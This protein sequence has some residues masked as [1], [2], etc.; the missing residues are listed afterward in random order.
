QV[1]H[2]PADQPGAPARLQ[3]RQRGANGRRHGRELRLPGRHVAQDT[4]AMPAVDVDPE[5]P[6]AFAARR[7]HNPA[8]WYR[9][10]VGLLLLLT[11]WIPLASARWTVRVEQRAEL[12]AGLLL[13]VAR[14][15]QPIDFGAPGIGRHVLARL[16]CAATAAGVPCDDVEF[17]DELAPDSLT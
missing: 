4:G 10:L 6:A 15:M 7:G 16:L 5:R 17:V 11:L 2:R 1:A 12:L 3:A 8:M 9:G 14:P 13:D